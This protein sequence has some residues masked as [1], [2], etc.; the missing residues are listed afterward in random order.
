MNTNTTNTKSPSPR[1]RRK[2]TQEVL[3]AEIAPEM[4]TVPVTDLSPTAEET[5]PLQDEAPVADTITVEE[6]A[7]DEELNPDKEATITEEIAPIKEKATVKKAKRARSKRPPFPMR[8]DWRNFQYQ[9][10][11]AD[12]VAKK[13]L[14]ERELLLSDGTPNKERIESEAHFFGSTLAIRVYESRYMQN[15]GIS[16][17]IEN[18]SALI[19]ND[20]VITLLYFY[21]GNLYGAVQWNMPFNLQRLPVNP[22]ALSVYLYTFAESFLNAAEKMDLPHIF[23][24]IGE[25]GEEPG[26]EQESSTEEQEEGMIYENE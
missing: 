9:L 14:I 1:T 26:N 22:E 25:N 2:N 8:Q 6:N 21:I 17:I 23:G 15:L 11:I 10:N 20:D 24:G 4:E 3:A 18:I 12:D 5:L 13:L 7:S 19:D 16:D